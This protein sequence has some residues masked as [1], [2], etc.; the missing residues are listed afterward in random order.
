MGGFRPWAVCVEPA[1]Y[2]RLRPLVKPLPVTVSN[3]TFQNNPSR[4]PARAA[5]APSLPAV[6]A[7]AV[8]RPAE[9]CR[10]TA[11]SLLQLEPDPVAEQSGNRVQRGQF[12]AWRRTFGTSCLDS[13]RVRTRSPSSLFSGN[14]ARGGN[15]PQSSRPETAPEGA[16]LN[17]SPNTTITGTTFLN[18]TV[19]GGNATGIGAPGNARGGK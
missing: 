5:P 6:A 7:R 15:D 1:R 10:P 2:G 19:Q 14:L 16:I 9:P 17:D 3:T 4:W 18:N 8:M 13:R 11:Y 12:A